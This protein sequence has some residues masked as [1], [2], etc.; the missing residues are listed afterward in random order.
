MIVDG[1]MQPMEAGHLPY[2]DGKTYEDFLGKRGFA[3]LGKKKWLNAVMDVIE[4]FKH[5]LEPDYIVLGGGNAKKLKQ[6]ECVMPE[7]V[8][9]RNKPKVNQQLKK[10]LF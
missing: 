5:A 7:Q 4:R 6:E 10:M 1:V 3:E 8:L 9:Q 2:K